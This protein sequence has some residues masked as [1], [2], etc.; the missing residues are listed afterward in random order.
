VSNAT[1]T[2]D[3][4]I[5]ALAGEAWEAG[6]YE[7]V[8]ICLRALGVGLHAYPLAAT[9]CRVAARMTMTQARVECA[10]VMSETALAR[11]EAV[12]P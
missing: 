5:E 12:R 3:A 6:D 2:P 4:R 10:R 11:G 1:H 7:M 8:A 9:D